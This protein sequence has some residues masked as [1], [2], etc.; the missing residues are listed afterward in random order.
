MAWRVAPIATCSQLHSQH[1]G[2]HNA[3]DTQLLLSTGKGFPLSVLESRIAAGS[4]KEGD[5]STVPVGTWALSA[6]PTSATEEPLAKSL[7]QASPRSCL[8][9]D[10]GAA[11]H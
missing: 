4:L 6:D 3:K 11:R 2:A 1:S 8:L 9:R 10:R 7:P 5:L